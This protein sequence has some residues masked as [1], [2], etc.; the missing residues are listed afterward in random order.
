MSPAPSKQPVAI[1]LADVTKRRAALR[2]RRTDVAIVA[3][4]DTLSKQVDEI[5][6][7]LGAAAGAGQ[8]IDVEAKLQRAER[9]VE[10]LE[11]EVQRIRRRI[12]Q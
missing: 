10:A 9:D 11:G 1:R 5:R 3:R 8:P 12:T 2:V 4:L 7:V 6:A